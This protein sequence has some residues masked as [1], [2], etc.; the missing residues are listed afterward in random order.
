MKNHIRLI[1]SNNQSTIQ[2]S[3]MTFICPYSNTKF[4]RTLTFFQRAASSV[5]SAA[6]YPHSF[7]KSHVIAL[8]LSCANWIQSACCCHCF[9]LPQRPPLP[10]ALSCVART[11]DSHSLHGQG[12]QYLQQWGSY[13]GC[14]ASRNRDDS[15][16]HLW[17]SG[18][19]HSICSSVP[20]QWQVL[21]SRSA[22]FTRR[23]HGQVVP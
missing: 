14:R 18:H 17:R 11:K 19:G 12:R 3:N 22:E 5:C 10:M 2:S 20:R 21:P 1:H 8:V 15:T 16:C 13:A 9:S 4:F 6:C 23:G 7:T